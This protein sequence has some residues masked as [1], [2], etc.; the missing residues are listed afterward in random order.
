MK[1]LLISLLL[2]SH[3]FVVIESDGDDDDDGDGKSCKV[4]KYKRKSK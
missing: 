2:F 1:L 4:V 3:L